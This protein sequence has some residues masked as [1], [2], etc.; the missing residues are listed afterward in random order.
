MQSNDIFDIFV[1]GGGA[2]G[3]G[4]ALDASIKGLI[5]KNY[6]I[7]LGFKVALVDKGDFSSGTSSK[8]TKLIHGGVRYLQNAVFNFDINEVF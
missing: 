7:D 1:I 2:T 8:S 4:V 3:C 5:F 6:Y